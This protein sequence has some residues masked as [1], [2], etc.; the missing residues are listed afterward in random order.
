M[1]KSYFE[2]RKKSDSLG[3]RL[4]PFRKNFGMRDCFF[5]LSGFLAWL[6]VLIGFHK[7]KVWSLLPLL[8][9]PGI[10]MIFGTSFGDEDFS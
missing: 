6:L 2:I 9:L 7:G 4:F 5:I 10:G 1:L 3:V 8:N